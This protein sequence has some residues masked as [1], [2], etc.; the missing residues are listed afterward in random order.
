MKFFKINSKF[1]LLIFFA[2]CVAT[3]NNMQNQA[4]T[5]VKAKKKQVVQKEEITDPYADN[6]IE[7]GED[8]KSEEEKAW[9]ADARKLTDN[10][11]TFPSSDELT[12]FIDRS[13]SSP[14]IGCGDFYEDSNGVK[15]LANPAVRGA[16][17]VLATMFQSCSA[18]D[19]II[20]VNTPSLRGIRAPKSAAGPRIRNITD[21]KAYI[22][23]HI[24]LKDLGEDP[25]YPGP[26][27]T[28]ARLKPPVYG[29]GS[30]KA[31]NRS[32]ELNLFTKGEGVSSSSKPAAG[33]DC[34]SFISVALASQGLKVQTDSGPFSS[35][36]TTNFNQTLHS[37]KSCLDTAKFDANNTIQAGDMINVSGNHI[38]MV[39]EIGNDPLAI[40]KYA[41]ANNCKGIKISDFNF[42]YIHSGSINNGYGP[43]RVHIS[44]HNGGTMFNNLRLSAV[45]MCQKIVKGTQTEVDSKKLTLSPKFDIIRHRTSDPEC[46]SDKRIKLKGED[47]INGCYDKATGTEII[48]Q[49]NTR[50]V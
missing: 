19:K 44:K 43:S 30:R 37:K 38:V 16:R 40:K 9:E 39:D 42:T 5:L 25:N 45:K 14:S 41:K 18:I 23:S 6:S 50:E 2:S 34:S 24:V 4:E 10:F 49:R 13:L 17:K 26:Q 12:G 22:S 27:C 8:Y 15:R 35:L 20:D 1:L 33:I 47:C 21:T 48:N 28:D 11:T 7:E 36:T 31:P 32:G 29:Y 3:Q 46:I